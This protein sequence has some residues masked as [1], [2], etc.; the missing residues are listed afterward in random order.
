MRIVTLTERWP[1]PTGVATGPLSATLVSRIESN[2]SCGKS[3]PPLAR[4]T[5]P[6]SRRRHSK[7]TPVASI[8]LSAASVISGPIPSPGIKVTRCAMCSSLVLAQPTR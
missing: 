6:T 8:T 3:S 2:T 5:S 4:L 7:A 1:L